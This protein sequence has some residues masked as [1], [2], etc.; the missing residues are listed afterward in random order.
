MTTLIIFAMGI[1]LNVPFIVADPTRWWNWVSL[2]FCFGVGV[3]SA[4]MR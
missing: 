3:V 2:V 4:R 1:L